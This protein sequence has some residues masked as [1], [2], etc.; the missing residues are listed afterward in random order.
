MSFLW[1]PT[2]QQQEWDTLIDKTTSDLL[3]AQTPLDLVAA[4]QLADL[5]RSAS[6]IPAYASRSLLR[7][8]QYDN[9]NVQ[10]LALELCD[11]C[12]KNGGTAFLVQFAK[13]AFEGGVATDLELLARGV[14]S[15]GSVHRD[16][17]DKV[18]ARLQDWATAFKGKDQLRDSELVRVYD[19]L[20][21]EGVQFPPRDPTATAAMVD[22]LSAPDWTDSPYCTRCRTEFSTFNRKH[23]CRNCGQVFDQQ[24]SSSAAPLPHY[25]ILEP[26]RVCDGC[27]KKIREGKGGS[28]Q[29][30]ASYSA[31]QREAKRPAQVE[32]SKTV[33]AKGGLSRKEQEDEDLRKAI[34]A[35][36]K[37]VEPDQL[38][39]A[40]P[41]PP[42]KSGYN[43][44]YASQISDSKGASSSAKKDEEDDPDL[45]AAI[46][47]S[48][49]DLQPPA[50]APSFAR[51]ESEA[52]IPTST[53]YSSLFPSS[54]AYDSPAASRPKP[55]SLPSYDLSATES[56]LLSDFTSLFA[57]PP[58]PPYLGPKERRMY[59]EAYATQGRLDRAMEDARRR[60][61]I[62][63]EMEWKLGEAARLYGAGLTE[64]ASYRP[65]LSNRLSS[66]SATSQ[67]Y[68]QPQ[69]HQPYH[70][71]PAA[72]QPLD[73]RYQYAPPPALTGQPLPAYAIPVAPVPPSAVPQHAEVASPPPVQAY[74]QSPHQAQPH[75]QPSQPVPAGYYK[76]SSFPSV[77]TG[78]QGALFPAVPK[79]E[80]P[81][82]EEP[83]Q[84]EEEEEER[85]RTGE[86]IEL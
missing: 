59:D 64:R 27:A 54:T 47:A 42:A 14:K 11:V 49:R 86:L 29:R 10:L 6:V 43:P 76:P 9:P 58:Y 79:G 70:A 24:C 4:L 81:V 16:V 34:E 2:Q 38:P 3:P 85:G 20:V 63:S 75:R 80:L 48:L 72:A 45:A 46:A 22:S 50:T 39:R 40:H 30:H 65:P 67:A 15:G 83:E 8:I 7:R 57:S 41:G 18:L 82:E 71:P 74:P 69:H 66:Y 12:V 56:A 61:E 52:T 73:A 55:M 23:H 33:S 36:L 37:E 60:R 19:K 35:S 77:P 44:S 28:V 78:A 21:K 62:L 1:G 5:V 53:A 32:R 25:G 31:G 51:S 68:A 17:K 84:E 13:T 26:V